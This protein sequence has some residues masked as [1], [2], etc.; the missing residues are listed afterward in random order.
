MKNV[1]KLLIFF[2]ILFL[3]L[4]VAIANSQRETLILFDSSGSMV[5]P[6]EGKTKIE[7]A[8]DAVFNLLQNMPNDEKIGLRTIGV[9]PSQIMG[10]LNAGRK[11]ICQQTY[12]HTPIRMYN[13]E[14]ILGSLKELYPFGPSPLAYALRQVVENDFQYA[15]PEKHIILITDGYET[16]DGNPCEY[17]KYL[18]TQR[19]DLIIDV[20]AIGANKYD[21]S[22]LKCLT[23]STGGKIYDV[24][25]PIDITPVVKQLIRDI[26]PETKQ[27]NANQ[28]VDFKQ[29]IQQPV[30]F[31]P[32]KNIIYKNY[33]LEFYD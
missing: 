28:Q 11:E 15:S 10:L 30:K 18:M 20:I 17:I 2:V 1:K 12:L 16:C 5:D 4:N 8:A 7:H 6:F 29:I 26:S 19:K 21:L 24:Q 31:A 9:H 3:S 32:K 23:D 22:Y 14:N 33:L 27:V 13:K 25:R